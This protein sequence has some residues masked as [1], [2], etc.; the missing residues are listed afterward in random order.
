MTNRRDGI[1]KMFSFIV[2]GPFSTRKGDGD[3]KLYVREREEMQLDDVL[4]IQLLEEA[5][6]SA[7]PPLDDHDL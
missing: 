2:H 6:L 4:M 5:E 3:G 7:L 1:K